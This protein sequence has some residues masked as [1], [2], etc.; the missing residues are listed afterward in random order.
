MNK[1]LTTQNKLTIILF[2]ILIIASFF[3]L[4]NIKTIP[5]GLYPD[6]AI[7]G[8]N[9]LTALETGKF[10]VFY[11]EN[12]GR[13]GLFI[14]IQALLL[15]FFLNFYNN[16]EPWMLRIVSAIF[17]ILTVWGLYFLAKQLFN[18][19]IGLLCSFLLAVGFW[20]VNFSRI[21]FRAIMVPFCL[22]WSIYFLLKA[23]EK[24]NWKFALFS[25][26][27]FGAGFHTYI[28]YRV[29]PLIALIIFIYYFLKY[30]R[31]KNIKSFWKLVS[32]WIIVTFII[33]LPIGLYFLHNPQDFFGR[34]TQV[35]IF[36]SSNPIK[37]LA[38]SFIKEIGMFNVRGD[39]NW[40][41]NYSCH[42]E[43]DIFTGLF[44]LIGLIL[45]IKNLFKKHFNLASCLLIGWFLI[46]ILPAILT[47]EGLPHALRSIGLIPPVFILAGVGLNSFIEWP[48][49]KIHSQNKKNISQLVLVVICLSILLINYINYFQ[50]WAK[51]SN[52]SG[53][54]NENY[55]QIGQYLNSLPQSQ[56]KIV[57]V[58]AGGVLVNNIPMP[59]QT[60]MF[61]TDTYT[62][63]KQQQKN[64][65]YILPDQLTQI[66]TKAETSFVLI[67]LEK[68]KETKEMIERTFPNITLIE[69]PYFWIFQFQ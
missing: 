4:S 30:H 60:T 22:V 51:N 40:R 3:R 48:I 65:I 39:C 47:T 54:F 31:Q 14:N 21:G 1:K 20:H 64:I 43:L 25:A 17:G 62:P 59:S 52:V 8:N 11:P 23:L 7:N 61:I 41:H 29:S 55:K 19:K 35:S 15:K 9:A 33:A 12:N 46:M 63:E 28:A 32:L 27:F 57:L 5:P 13:E 42:P 36:N 34:S 44:F 16:P 56:L 69:N 49:S 26:V 18:S 66:N 45:T 24:N 6:E 58:N 50:R 37:E 53:A 38:T 2:I 68:N 67:P 10:K